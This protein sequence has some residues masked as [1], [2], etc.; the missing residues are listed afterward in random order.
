[1]ETRD[2]AQ[3][4]Q[5]PIE[6]VDH[7][8]PPGNDMRTRNA[9]QKQEPANDA[10][11]GPQ[12]SVPGRLVHHFHFVD[13]VHRAADLLD[14]AGD[15][16]E[17]DVLAFYDDSHAFGLFIDLLDG[18]NDMPAFPLLGDSLGKD[19]PIGSVRLQDIQHQALHSY[20]AVKSRVSDPAQY[21]Q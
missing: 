20:H 5:G 6:A 19:Q 2:Y 12:R 4:G 13:T 21:T 18:I 16:F 10:Y 11:I 3:H 1:M 15:A 17:L 9:E 14:G 7:E 8:I